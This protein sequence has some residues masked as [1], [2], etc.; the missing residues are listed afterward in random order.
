MSL[1]LASD[2]ASR[3]CFRYVLLICVLTAFASTSFAQSPKTDTLIRNAVIRILRSPY[4]PVDKSVRFEKNIVDLNG[5]GIPEVAVWVSEPLQGG[6]SG[7]PAIIL[8]RSGNGYRQLWQDSQAWTPMILLSTK[9]RNGFHDIALQYGGGGAVWEF[10]RFR[11]NGRTYKLSTCQK[12]QPQG[13]ILLGKG[14]NQST[15]GPITK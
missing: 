9:G 15:F 5:D 11:Y 2:Y 12:R 8:T 14:W 13:R 3:L 1:S 4:D 10:C 6:S 7:Y